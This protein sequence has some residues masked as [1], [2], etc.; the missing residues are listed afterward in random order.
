[1]KAV[2]IWAVSA[3]L[4]IA[5]PAAI[6]DSDDDANAG[7]DALNKG[8]YASAVELFSRALGSGTLSPADREYAYVKRGQAYLGEHATAKANADFDQALKLNPK[9]QEAI[10]L[11][12]QARQPAGA[13]MHE[14]SGPSLATTLD[15]MIKTLTQQ[16]SINA[17]EAVHDSIRNLDSAPIKLFFLIDD[18]TPSPE[19]CELGLHGVFSQNGVEK[20]NERDIV[21]FKNIDRITVMTYDEASNRLAAKNGHPQVTLQTNPTIYVVGIQADGQG[22]DSNEWL[23]Y[24]EDTADRV[25]KALTH[26]TELCGGGKA[27]PF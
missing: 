19:K 25:A 24:D 9:D 10:A 23:F 11:R 26:A 16:G 1:M 7:L 4:L 14:T 6:A 3:V 15:F 2:R 21:Q 27:D 20:S 5:S 12:Q 22:K 13:P 18:F 8:S 17:I